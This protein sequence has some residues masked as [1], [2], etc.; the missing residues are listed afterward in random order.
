MKIIRVESC[1]GCPDCLYDGH[2]KWYCAVRPDN[3][4]E[5]NN[6]IPSWC[7]LEDAPNHLSL[8]T[9]YEKVGGE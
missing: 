8:G 5:K 7:P 2:S 3:T 4:L 9:V 6:I 1:S